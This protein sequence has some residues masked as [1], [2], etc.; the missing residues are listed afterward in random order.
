[1]APQAQ[2]VKPEDPEVREQIEA[3]YKHYRQE[4]ECLAKTI[5]FESRGESLQGQMA[6]AWVTLNRTKS[7]KFAPTVCGVVYQP[8]QYSWVKQNNKVV[9][10]AGYVHATE[11]A[12]HMMEVFESGE[13]PKVLSK[14]KNAFY[15]DSLVPRSTHVR[16]GNHNFR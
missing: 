14:V 6:V 1:M 11:L 12:R 5:Y 15:F 2:E 10:I 13:V 3:Q 7:E 4:V 16:I 8:K 9:D